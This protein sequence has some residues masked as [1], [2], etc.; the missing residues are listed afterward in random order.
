MPGT[1]PRPKEAGVTSGRSLSGIVF[2]GDLLS[3]TLKNADLEAALKEIARKCN[4]EIQIEA[5]LEEEIT[6][7]FAGLPL[8]KGLQK[9]LRNQSYTFLYGDRNGPDGLE[10][11]RVMAKGPR[12]GPGAGRAPLPSYQGRP[13]RGVRT[14]PTPPKPVE[15]RPEPA[16]PGTSVSDEALETLLS[17]YSEA[18][19]ETLEDVMDDM[20][21]NPD[22][23]RPRLMKALED[24]KGGGAAEKKALKVILE[25]ARQG[26]ED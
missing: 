6:M 26:G 23:I 7:Q 24:A 25:G 17:R 20:E 11:V 2:Q 1:V 10:A 8:D 22:E 18:G 15:D 12:G 5:P 3:V 14:E 4:L 19:E 16:A 9:L 13:A 21:G